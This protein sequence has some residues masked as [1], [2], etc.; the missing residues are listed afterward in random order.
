MVAVKERTKITLLDSDAANSRLTISSNSVSSFVCL[1][2][3]LF[4]CLFICLYFD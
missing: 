1:L 3:Y 4:V 2:D